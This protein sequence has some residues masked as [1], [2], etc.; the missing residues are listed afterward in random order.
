M[1]VGHVDGGEDVSR[2]ASKMVAPCVG[3]PLTPGSLLV[4]GGISSN[5]VA[6]WDI[7]IGAGPTNVVIVWYIGIGRVSSN[8]VAV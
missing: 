4:A 2:S 7:D 8:V 3:T 1:S 6:V 5:V